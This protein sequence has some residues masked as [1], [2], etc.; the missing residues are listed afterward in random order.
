MNYFRLVEMGKQWMMAADF[1][2]ETQTLTTH[3]T[4]RKKNPADYH[5]TVLSIS[6]VSG[7]RTGHHNNKTNLVQK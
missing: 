5:V 3:L 7:T 1:T 6:A 4:K 2:H